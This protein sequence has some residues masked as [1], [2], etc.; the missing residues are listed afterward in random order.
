MEDNKNN[1]FY[2]PKIEYDKNY[3]TEGQSKSSSSSSSGE[4]ESHNI[5]YINYINNKVKR[6]YSLINILPDDLQKVAKN[7]VN[8]I[9]EIIGD[10]PDDVEPPE[11]IHETI[12]IDPVVPINPPD[13]PD[14]PF[15]PDEPDSIK[16]EIEN[17]D[18]DVIIRNQYYY[19]LV[20]IVKDY[21]DNLNTSIDNYIN[22]LFAT[23]QDIDI[24]SYHNSMETYKT[25]C[26]KIDINLKHLSDT[27]IRSQIARQMK[28]KLYL[29]LYDIDKTINHI[30]SCKAGVELRLRYHKASY[31]KDT[32]YNEAVSNKILGQNRL[33]YD[34]KYKQNFINLYKYLNSSVIMLNECLNM[35]ITEIQSK[36]ILHEKG[37]KIW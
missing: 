14:Y 35:N 4:T 6:Y 11:R 10:V 8:I 7:P 30:R 25:S 12:T 24:E 3:E 2:N 29:K 13:Y 33:L 34:K 1:I 17:D 37:E 19:D 28:E 31:Y 15:D 9:K 20:S 32:T 23:F 27:I 21:V 36:L 22:A 18:D 16:V 26:R 5:I